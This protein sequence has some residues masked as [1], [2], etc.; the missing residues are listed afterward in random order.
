[1]ELHGKTR[2]KVYLKLSLTHT[3]TLLTG[4]N[5]LVRQDIS[6]V[7]TNECVELIR[8]EGYGFSPFIKSTRQRNQQPYMVKPQSQVN[9]PKHIYKTLH[10]A[11]HGDKLKFAGRT[12]LILQLG[13]E[14]MAPWLNGSGS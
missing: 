4:L 14:G 10:T 7:C 1:M 11:T 9:L 6:Y 5:N 8:S 13:N 12:P 2:K 3:H